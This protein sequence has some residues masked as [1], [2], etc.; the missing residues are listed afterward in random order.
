MKN[1]ILS[2]IAILGLA[3]L[4]FSSCAKVPQ[5]EI[6]AANE[7]IELAKSA[8]ADVYIHDSFVALQDSLN[9]VMVS[10]EAEKSKFFRNYASAKEH[11]A[12][13]T[14][15][16][17]EV[18]QQAENRK[19][20][21]KVEIQNTIAEVKTLVESNRKLILEAP[22]GKEGTSALEAI[23]GEIDAIESSINETSTLFEAGDYLSSLDKAKVA[24]EKSTAINT[25]LTDVIAKY[26][27]NVKGKRS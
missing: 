2:R 10:I 17:G 3:T 16:A 21:L 11:L 1:R 14:Q 12:G 26:K 25:E 13:V 19:E 23:K 4:L 24:L 8:G 18:K 7:A 15:Y 5:A 20:E 22:K 6:D 9:S 27:S